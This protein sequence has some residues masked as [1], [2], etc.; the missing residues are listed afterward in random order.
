[1]VSYK[2]QTTETFHNWIDPADNLTLELLTLNC[3]GTHFCHLKASGLERLIMV[4]LA[5]GG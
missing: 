5:E 1:M 2:P 3:K 4:S